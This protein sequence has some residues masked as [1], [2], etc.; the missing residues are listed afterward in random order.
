M[1]RPPDPPKRRQKGFGSYGT[2]PRKD[3]RWP[4]YVTLAPGKRRVV[5]G[6]TEAEM[7]A[8][9][10]ALVRMQAEGRDPPARDYTVQ[11][12]LSWWVQQ[13]R[14][15]VIGGKPLRP[16]T[17]IRYEILIRVQIAPEVGLVRLSR[18]RPSHLERL[19]A[20]LAVDTDERKKSSAR[21]RLHVHRFLHV[22]L[23][24]AERRGML[25]RNPCD[26]VDPPFVEPREPRELDERD[27]AAIL[28]VASGHAC[29]AMLWVAIAGGLRRGELLALLW[30]DVDLDKGI[31]W[32]RE[33]VQRLTGM[34][35]VRSEPKS[36]AGK[37]PMMLPGVALAAL[38]DHADRQERLGRPNPLGLVFPSRA[39]THFEQQNWSRDVW[40]PWLREAKR[41]KLTGLPETT[42]F[43]ELTRK[44]H[45]S[46][47]V[48]LGV[49]PETLRR[50]M[51][52]ARVDV[53]YAHYV[54][55]LMSSDARAADLLDRELR[56]LAGP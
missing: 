41:R 23:K 20:A 28:K 13:R 55:S 11:V 22:A 54:Q 16:S 3:G 15:G 19:Y 25:L 12:Y 43:R 46:L 45:S 31:V 6:R 48:A 14:D 1:A 18:L 8:R 24:Y 5:Y 52:H 47:L 56:K 35:Q 33:Q 26:L 34:G 50:R 2:K 51:G 27:V 53:T 36:R 10:D 7:Q 37:R 30:A 39:G 44:A 9:V 38:R 49:D 40:R 4:G 29:E 32:V 17:V 21:T 42:K